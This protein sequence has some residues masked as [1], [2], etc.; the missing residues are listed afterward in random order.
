MQ[1]SIQ[2]EPAPLR[3]RP[4][5]AGSGSW[6]GTFDPPHIGHLW[7]ATLVADALGLDRV[8]LM[9]AAQPPHKRRQRLI[10]NAAGP[11]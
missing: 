7:L 8:L 2:E 9:P 1:A 11:A 5:R 10:S 6:G 3:G 4:P